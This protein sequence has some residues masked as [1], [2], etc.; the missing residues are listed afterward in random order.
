MTFIDSHSHLILEP[1]NNDRDTVIQEAFSNG[2]TH[3]VQSCD[4]LEEVERNLILTKKY[5]N[6][7]SSVGIHPHEAKLWQA[8]TKDTIIKYTKEETVIAIGETGLDFYYNYSSKEEQLLAFKEQIK[9][10]K[11][12]S[13]PLIIHCRDAFKE[14]LEMLKEEKPECAGVFHC[15]TGDLQTARE[16]IKLG[17]YISWSGILTFNNATKLKEAAREISLT[18]SLIETDCPFLTP[19]PHRGK[20]NEPKYVRFVAEELAKIHNVSVDEVGE[21]TSKNT[22]KLFGIK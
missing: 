14:A 15:Y 17:F 5:K 11:E 9:I 21:I 13:L 2:I 18:N 7:Y 1:F 20:R 12:V 4:N 8:V 10:A 6:L 19:I 3:I 22:K 16:A